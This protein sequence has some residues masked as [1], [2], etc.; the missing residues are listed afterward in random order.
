MVPVGAGRLILPRSKQGDPEQTM[1]IATLTDEDADRVFARKDGRG[2]LYLQPVSG[3]KSK[4]QAKSVTRSLAPASAPA[5][6]QEEDCG[7]D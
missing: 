3:K 4:K 5:A 7:C 2:E 6:E 1:N